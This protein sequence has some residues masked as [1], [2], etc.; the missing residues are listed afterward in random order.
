M[1]SQWLARSSGTSDSC[2]ISDVRRAAL[3]RGR[4][5]HTLGSLAYG[6]IT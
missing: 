5:L 3:S 4:P 2:S 6:D 1:A